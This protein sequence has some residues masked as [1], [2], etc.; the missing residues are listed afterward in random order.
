MSEENK[1]VILRPQFDC[2]G[3]CKHIVNI[4][5]PTGAFAGFGCAKYKLN[6]TRPNEN[7]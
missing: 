5:A 7:E 1:E 3:T 6:L 4:I 2:C